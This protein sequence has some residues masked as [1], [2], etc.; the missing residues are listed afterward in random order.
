MLIW[1]S[2]GYIYIIYTLG[3]YTLFQEIIQEIVS[4]IRNVFTVMLM[5][6]N[7]RHSC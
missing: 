4:Y 3:I 2:R 1:C 7:L 6:T 5:L